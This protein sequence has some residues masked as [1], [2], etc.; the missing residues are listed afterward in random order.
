M[1]G[2]WMK[3]TASTIATTLPARYPLAASRTVTSMLGQ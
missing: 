1:N 2:T 3:T